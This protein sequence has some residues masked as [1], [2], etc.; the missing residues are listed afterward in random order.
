MVAKFD[1]EEAREKVNALFNREAELLAQLD[2]PQIVKLRDHFTEDGRKYMVLDHISGRTLRELVRSSGVLK[3]DMAVKIAVQM[4]GILT[5][6]H[7]RIPPIVHRDFTPDNIVLH[8][9]GTIVLIDFGAANEFLAEATGTL[10]GKQG[11][12]PAEQIRGKAVPASDLYALGATIYFL[13]TGQDPEALTSCDLSEISVSPE[14]RK[15]VSH[16]TDLSA[17]K[18]PQSA[19]EVGN[20]LLDFNSTLKPIK[21]SQ[22]ST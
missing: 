7:E 4:A 14:L 1:N 13:L 15:L 20:S 18:R 3:E 8:N 17:D 12:M 6:L 11:Y 19:A 16:L 9:D 22:S 10:I 5:Y 21:D 2:H